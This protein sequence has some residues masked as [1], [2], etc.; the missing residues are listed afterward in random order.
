MLEVTDAVL[1]AWIARA[2]RDDAAA[3]DAWRIAVIKEDMLNYNE[4][5]DWF[6]PSRESL[7]AALLRA[8]RFPEAEQAFRD[9]LTRNPKN[10]RSLYGLWQ[11]ML[12]S[13]KVPE[14]QAVEAAEKQFRDA[15]KYADVM[16]NIEEM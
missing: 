15:W 10:G 4:P 11:T 13:R 12:V 1:D 2:R 14:K 7:G 16:L 3:I 9:D 8:K 5:A 6:Y